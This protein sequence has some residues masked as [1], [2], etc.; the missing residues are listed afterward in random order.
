MDGKIVNGGTG[1]KGYIVGFQSRA[2][3]NHE[4]VDYWFSTSPKDGMRWDTRELAEAD[5]L[6]FNRGITINHDL[7]RP[8]VLQ[9]FEVEEFNDG[10]IVG[11]EGP[12]AIRGLGQGFPLE[13][14]S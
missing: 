9:S 5:V 11:C 10:F 14:E 1:M 2:S 3:A 6:I 13:E 7:H 12:F 8:Y 4:I